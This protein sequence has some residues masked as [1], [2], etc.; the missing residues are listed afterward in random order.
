MSWGMLKAL[1]RVEPNLTI[2]DV[3]RFGG[4]LPRLAMT[5]TRGAA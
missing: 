2:G 1:I 5:S 4:L 3:A